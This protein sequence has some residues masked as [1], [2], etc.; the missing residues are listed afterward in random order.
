LLR[1]LDFNKKENRLYLYD[2]KVWRNQKVQM[3]VSS[4]DF[5]SA[6]W[7]EPGRWKA[8]DFILVDEAAFV[9]EDVWLN[10]LPILSNE[11]ARFYA[12]STIQWETMRN[13]FYEQLVD[14]E[15]W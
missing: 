6:K 14:A 3:I 2:E 11:R 15:M 7:Y 8:S 9:N 10:V 5:V 1:V 12:V 4:C 13:W